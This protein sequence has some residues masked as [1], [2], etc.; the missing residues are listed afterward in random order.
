MSPAPRA[1]PAA[2]SSPWRAAA[3]GGG[4][5]EPRDGSCPRPPGST[6]TRARAPQP[7]AAGPEPLRRPEARPCAAS[8]RTAGGGGRR[9]AAG[10]GLP[11]RRRRRRRLR[12]A[13]LNGTCGQ[14]TANRA[15]RT[16][17][18]REGGPAGAGPAGHGR[19]AS[20]PAPG[21]EGPPRPAQSWPRP[22][23]APRPRPQR[24]A[25]APRPRPRPWVDLWPRRLLPA[26]KLCPQASLGLGDLFRAAAPRHC[27]RP[28][29]G[30]PW[31][32]PSAL[33]L[34]PACCPRPRPDAEA[35]PPPAAWLLPRP[36]PASRG[37]APTLPLA[38]GSSVRSE[39]LGPA[40]S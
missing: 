7:V 26:L 38:L 24:A 32:R 27:L 11:R 21:A 9:A 35:P 37:P 36:A 19:R 5:A 6:A 23:P 2:A 18:L 16:R 22:R 39:R 4:A 40:P 13:F 30:P 14:R 8:A 25:S 20:G 12:S 34:P 28:S 10:P 29:S 33:A 3:G 31:A 17:S 1:L 15:A